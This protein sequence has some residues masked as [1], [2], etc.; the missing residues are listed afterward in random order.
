[1]ADQPTPAPTANTAYEWD[2]FISHAG[3]DLEVARKLKRQL[4]PPARVFLDKESIQPSENWRDVLED[5]LES[6]RVYVVFIS[7]SFEEAFYVEEELT[8]AI[9][10]IRRD[11]QRRIM[12][13]Y[14]N[15]NEV[16]AKVPVGLGNIQGLPLPDPSDLSAVTQF[17][18]G[19]LKEVRPEVARKVA[20]VT[21]QRDAIEKLNSGGRADFVTGLRKVVKP[22]SPIPEILFGLFLLM[23]AATFLC[24]FALRGSEVQVLA[25]VVCLIM[26][27]FLLISL[28][29]LL[30]LSLKHS[31]R[32]ASGR[33]D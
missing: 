18:I 32:I 17:L 13:V 22:F 26:W 4:D 12:P 1:M 6:T 9:D 28:L 15:V 5:A 27:M 10:M 14:L 23:T 24:L 3:G 2:V 29:I 31:P 7:P 16:P 21:G 30:V 11:S 20:V 33:I 8:I 25:V 19:K